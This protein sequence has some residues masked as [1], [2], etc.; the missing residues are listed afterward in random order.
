MSQ[1]LKQQ[2]LNQKTA[3]LIEDHGGLNYLNASYIHQFAQASIG[4]K[5][6]ILDRLQPDVDIDMNDPAWKQAI[7]VVFAFIKRYKLQETRGC[8]ELEFKDLPEKTGFAK[9]KDLD[10][11]FAQVASIVKTMRERSFEKNVSLFVAENGLK[12]DGLES[13]GDGY[14]RSSGQHRKHDKEHR[15]SHH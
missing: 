5:D 11:F 3:K 15:R 2:E 13:Q 7:C 8:M 9:S 12:Q 1:D 4:A 10:S 6:A 14:V